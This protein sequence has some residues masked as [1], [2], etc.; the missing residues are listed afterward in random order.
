MNLL[1]NQQPRLSIANLPHRV[2]A[3]PSPAMARGVVKCPRQKMP[4]KKRPGNR[5]FFCKH[6]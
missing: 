5:A 2:A 6:N 1:K 4:T 3:S